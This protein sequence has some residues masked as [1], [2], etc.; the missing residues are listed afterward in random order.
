MIYAGF[1]ALY[2]LWTVLAAITRR[3]PVSVVLQPVTRTAIVAVLTLA[4]WSPWLANLAQNFGSRFVGKSSPVGQGY[5]S[6]EA[7][8]ITPLLRHPSVGFLLVLM[9]GGIVW[10]ASRRDPL[11]LLPAITWLILGVWSNPYL[12]PGFRLPYAGYLDANTLATGAWLP[13]C[14]LA[15]Y[16]VARFAA[17]LAS[18]SDTQAGTISTRARIM[19]GL[20]YAAVALIALVGGL[21][22]AFQLATLQDIKPYIL[23]ADLDALTWMRTNLPRDAYVLANPFAWPW[24]A[25]PQAVQGSDAGLWVPLVAEVR[26]SVPPIPVYNERLADPRYT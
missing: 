9:L 20:T 7:M 18:L 8:G 24:D 16:W 1:V 22:S 13:V 4:A 26:S 6:L 21:A 11:P 23:P 3:R 10:A 15:G 19:S 17:W 12:F 25:P 2:L 5:Y 14:L